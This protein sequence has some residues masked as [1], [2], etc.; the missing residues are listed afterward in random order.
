MAA[1]FCDV[2]RTKSACLLR[3]LMQPVSVNMWCEQSHKAISAFLHFDGHFPSESALAGPLNFYLFCKRIFNISA[4]DFWPTV[5]SVVPLARC[6]VCL[7]VVCL[8]VTFCIVA[9]RYVLA[10]K[11]LKERIGNQGQKVDFLGRRHIFTSGF[12]A[13][14]METAVFAL[15]LHVQPNNRY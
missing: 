10:K 3:I 7:S 11:C 13:T 6:V 2:L 14:A 4:E 15:F 8:S 1:N 9:K 12:A 5:L